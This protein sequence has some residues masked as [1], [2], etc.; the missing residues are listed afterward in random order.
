MAS[1]DTHAEVHD[2]FN[3]RDYDGVVKR[4]ADDFH[5]T[6]HAR[7]ITMKTVEE[8]TA[9]LKEWATALDGRVTRARYLDAGDASVAR[10]VGRGSSIGPLGPLPATGRDVA[11]DL[12][13]IL[14]FDRE[15]MVT[16]GDIYYDQMGLMAQLGHIQPPA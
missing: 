1:A 3:T 12:C 13:E 4:M 16:G 7:N 2:L 14:T 15:G 9:W 8:F 11:F 10:F 5:Y 6:D